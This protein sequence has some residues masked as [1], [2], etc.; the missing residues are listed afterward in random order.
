M[1][2]Y[3][4]GSGRRAMR[5]GSRFSAYLA[6]HTQEGKG[7]GRRKRGFVVVR[8]APRRGVGQKPNTQKGTRRGTTQYVRV[9]DINAFPGTCT[10]S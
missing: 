4:Q 9:V 10:M 3:L 2:T 7:E 1:A 6:A 8:K 5:G